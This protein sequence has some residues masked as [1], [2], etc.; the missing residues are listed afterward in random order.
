VKKFLA[1]IAAAALMTG[2]A[3][4]ALAEEKAAEKGKMEAPAEKM[5]MKGK[6]AMGTVKAATADSLVVT[7]KG[8]TEW[9]FAIDDK[10]KITKANKSITAADIKAGDAVSVRYMEHDG[11]AVASR[12]VVRAAKNPCAAKK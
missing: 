12:V 2:F 9:T 1:A 5:P 10:T 8:G 3:G 11:K 4:L 6:P 7:G